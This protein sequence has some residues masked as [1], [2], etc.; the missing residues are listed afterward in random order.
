MYATVFLIVFLSLSIFK[1]LAYELELCSS[2]NFFSCF[3][4][5]FDIVYVSFVTNEHNNDNGVYA[6]TFDET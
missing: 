4:F 1:S 3:S 2:V 5:W 6:A